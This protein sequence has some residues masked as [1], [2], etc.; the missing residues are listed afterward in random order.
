M[1]MTKN[2]RQTQKR[3]PSLARKKLILKDT[4]MNTKYT[5]L[6][7][8]YVVALLVMIQLITSQQVF[9]QLSGNKSI[10]GDYG[11]IALAITDLNIAG[12]GPGGV[13]FNVAA[14]HTETL[15]GKITLTAT[16]TLANPIVIQKSGAGT[17]PKI[18]AYTGTVATPSVVA[19]GFFVLAG[20]DYVTIDGIDLEE[21]GANSTT[22]TMM[23]Y[24]YGLFKASATNGCQNNIIRNCTITLNRLQN[25]TW[26]TPGFNGSTGIA[27]LN[28]L[29]NSA[30]ALTVT[31]AA[32]S[33]SNNKFYTNTIQNCNAGIVFVGFAATLGVG[34]APTAGTFL[35][36]LNNDVGGSSSATGNNI[37]NFGGGAATNPSTGIHA[38]SQWSMNCSY[39]TL[40]NNDGSGVDH[41]TTLR[42]INF[43]TGATSAKLD[44]NYNNITLTGGGTTAQLSGIENQFGSTPLSSNTVNINNNTLAIE[45]RT[46]TSGPLYGILSSGATPAILNINNNTI[47]GIDYSATTLAGSGLVYGIQSSGSSA[48][49]THNINGNSISN[50]ARTGTSGGT[51]IGIFVSAGTTGMVVNANSNTISA[52][53]IGGTGTGSNMF[54][55]QTPTGTITCNNN[56]ISNLQISKTSG[57]GQLYGIYNVASP[58]NETYNNNTISSLTNAGTGAT[59]GML[60]NTVAGTRT[61]SGN[62]IHTISA[63]GTTVGG[64]SHTTS[65]PNINKN[66]IY[67]IQ[68]T[69]TGAPTVSGILVTS[70][71][72]SGSATIHNNLIGDLKAPNASTTSTVPPST[73]PTI[74]G[75]N[76]TATTTS[77]GVFIYY[78]TVL[79]EGTTSGT[80][81][82]TAALFVSGSSTST[83]ANLRLRNNILVN[84]C[85]A[86][87]TGYAVAYQRSSTFLNN[88]DAVSNNNLYFAGTPSATNLICYDGTN[89]Y[90]TLADFKAAMAT[91]D[92]ASVTENV[93]FTSTTGANSAFLQVVPGTASLAESGGAAISTFENDYAGTSVRNGY[94]KA[95]QVNGG[96]TAPDIGAYE[97]DG[98]PN[99][100]CVAPT[101]QATGLT[102]TPA[103]TTVN[104]SFTAA[105]PAASGYLVVAASG[106]APTNPVNGTSYSVGSTVLG[107][108][109]L[110]LYNGSATSFTGTGLTAL[111]AYTIYVY[112]YNNAFCIGGPSYNTTSPISASTTTCIA[113][114]SLNAITNL[115]T[116][117][118][119]ANW[120]A[121]SGATA[122]EL[123]VSTASNFSSFV[124]GYN[125]QNVGNVT[126][127]SIT[128]LTQGTTY[129]F[130]VRAVTGTCTSS[131][132]TNS[133]LT[134]VPM[135]FSESFASYPPA[136][137]LEAT[138]ALTSS[139]TLTGTASTWLG[140]NFANVAGNTGFKINLYVNPGTV[141]DWVISPNIF[142]GS[143]GAML[144]YRW[145]LTG[146]NNTTSQSDFGSHTVRVVISTDGGSTW[147][148]TNVIKTYS[149]TGSFSN[150][151]VF[152]SVVLTGYSGTIRIGFLA[153]FNTN[154]P[155]IDFHVDDVQ[156]LGVPS[157]STVPTPADLATG[158]AL[159]P[160]LSWG[161]VSDATQYDVFLNSSTPTTTLLAGNLTSATHTVASALSPNTTYYWKVVPKNHIGSATGCTDWSF[162]TGAPSPTISAGT[163][164]A[165]GNVCANVASNA[166]SFTVSGAF[167]NANVEVGAL[168]GYSYATTLNG[169]YTSTLSLAPSSGTL[170][171]TKVYVKFTPTSVATFNGNIAVTS[172]GATTQN[173][174][175][176]GSGVG[177][178]NPTLSS[179]GS[180]A[181]TSNS[182]ANIS[183]STVSSTGCASITGYG[184]EYSTTNGFT[185]G[186]GTQVSGTG[187]SGAAGGT[188]NTSLTGLTSNTTY[189]YR[190]YAT[191]S[192]GTAYSIQSSF[193]TPRSVPM[194]LHHTHLPIGQKLQVHCQ[195]LLP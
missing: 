194:H 100:V 141:N 160:T 61:V 15:S 139:A 146:W 3:L 184:I 87:G 71:G 112:A 26:T 145:A 115:L 191:N 148:T 25:T 78:N 79:I 39:N 92:A 179:A 140:S 99:A 128:G 90:Q 5:F 131:S 150:S 176:T 9:A 157:C 129:H 102:L 186:T 34:P 63:A 177:V 7:K 183:N 158:I 105:S 166:D 108:G 185:T 65:S 104:V 48:S 103:S 130:R 156:V 164:N 50:I 178:S 81:F 86:K 135:P 60:F 174:A 117:S 83:T 56:N 55:I 21:S 8:C 113:A 57:T 33:N 152:D 182:A 125:A 161:T 138:G 51:T 144:K 77:S 2:G 22:T 122:Y 66:K 159:L 41:T 82:G 16:G 107:A 80:N 118:F 111:T 190:S 172:T 18:T 85:T 53:D 31:T 14:G 167:L 30:S 106:A 52:F 69:S 75:I 12:V 70:M 193:K 95:G 162:T 49:M 36:D 43:A 126:T 23:E 116:T 137:W 45:Y 165:F 54:G 170:A 27:V 42:G 124:T 64:M 195:P 32:G 189:Y 19:D 62:I 94:P 73:A 93:Q 133:V 147:S 28:S 76:I 143:A 163:L 29:H 88:Y 121:V 72:A 24:G 181:V 180:A 37:L 132:G 114:P 46:A 149:G 67:N 127:F 123:D 169:T 44:C 11:T 168:A 4:Y 58:V 10:P 155:D 40:N 188:F 89:S 20:S 173:V 13:T 109:T 35:G 153:S 101:N 1:M 68:S 74:R 136:N 84:K 175:V 120:N 151:G 142:I 134:A 98:T 38:A 91:R 154:A 187:F 171:S 97:Y 6:K 192:S 59:W 96:G 47:S 17:N 119:S 110:V